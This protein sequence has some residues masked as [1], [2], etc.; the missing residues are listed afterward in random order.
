M[1]IANCDELIADLFVQRL[2]KASK[3]WSIL[4]QSILYACKRFDCLIICNPINKF[5]LDLI[6]DGATSKSHLI[7]K[8]TEKGNI[9]A[10]YILES[11]QCMKPISMQLNGKFYN[12]FY[13]TKTAINNIKKNDFIIKEQKYNYI[14]KGK[15][16]VLAMTDTQNDFITSDLDILIIS[17][18]DNFNT[19]KLD[20]SIGFGDILKY[21]YEIIQY[22][23]DIFSKFIL[24]I[25][26]NYIKKDVIRH[27]PFNRYEKS[28]ISDIQ[29]PVHVYTKNNYCLLRAESDKN[30]SF[31]NLMRLI[32]NKIKEGYQIFLPKMWNIN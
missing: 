10:G 13:D 16:I 1:Q 21:E 6:L 18:K 15:D 24:K 22:I 26:S 8:F 32:N 12:F 31:L 7:N 23:N 25:N 20:Y 2:R 29:F 9:L 3:V 14:L 4:N 27:G 30:M 28:K 17:T 11:V 5:A 19:E